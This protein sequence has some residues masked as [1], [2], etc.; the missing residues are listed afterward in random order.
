MSDAPIYFLVLAAVGILAA[1]FMAGQ[2]RTRGRRA[3]VM[4]AAF[5]CFSIANVAVYLGWP[6]WAVWA[7]GGCLAAFLIADIVLRS[8]AGKA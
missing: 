2:V 1:V 8:M 3:Y 5:V 4:S 7:A 6:A